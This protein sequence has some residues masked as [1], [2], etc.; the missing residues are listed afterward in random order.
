MRF[1]IRI[2]DQADNDLRT[3]YEYIAFELQSPEHASGQ[4]DRL[5]KAIIRVMYGGW[6]CELWSHPFLILR[7]CH[8]SV[9]RFCHTLSAIIH[10][11]KYAW[12]YEMDKKHILLKS[13]LLM[14][15]VIIVSFMGM[16]YTDSRSYQ[17]LVKDHVENVVRMASMEV[18]NKIESDLQVQLT[19]A[20]NMA[21][22]TFLHT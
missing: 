16:V 19:V 22:D 17:N 11:D 18:K 13:N 9:S 6:L 21:Q 12:R 4:L 7:L 20:E 8:T 5:E 2:S 3:I 10:M 15:V 14:I 1:E